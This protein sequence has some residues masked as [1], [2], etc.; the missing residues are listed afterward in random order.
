M[1]VSE[2]QNVVVQKAAVATV[3][4]LRPAFTGGVSVASLT[5]QNELNEACRVMYYQ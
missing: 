2:E 1:R 4:T 5:L 3:V